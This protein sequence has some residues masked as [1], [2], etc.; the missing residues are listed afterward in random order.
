MTI[1]ADTTLLVRAIMEDDERLYTVGTVPPSIVYS[2]PW[3]ADAPS[4]ARTAIRS[5]TSSGRAVSQNRGLRMP[6]ATTAS[7][8]KKTSSTA[9]PTVRRISTGCSARSSSRIAAVSAPPHSTQTS[10]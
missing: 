8:V 1:I 10:A 9:M 5:A 6:S 7:R 3:M 4:E 2:A